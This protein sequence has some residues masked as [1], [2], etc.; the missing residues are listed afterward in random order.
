M[1]LAS[2]TNEKR[3]NF[4]NRRFPDGTDLKEIK[5]WALGHKGTFDLVVQTEDPGHTICEHYG[6]HAN[7]IKKLY[8]ITREKGG[9][10]N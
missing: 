1:I 6:I 3:G 9:G 8:K 4:A 2:L 5:D 10:K 7:R